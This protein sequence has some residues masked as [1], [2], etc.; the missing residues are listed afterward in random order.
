MI[1]ICWIILHYCL[2]PGKPAV[3]STHTNEVYLLLFLFLQASYLS[4]ILVILKIHHVDVVSR[5]INHHRDCPS[6]VNV[7]PMEVIILAFDAVEHAILVLVT[8][9]IIVAQQFLIKSLRYHMDHLLIAFYVVKAPLI[10]RC[11]GFGFRFFDRLLRGL[12]GLLAHLIVPPPCFKHV[13]HR[14]IV[15]VGVFDH[16]LEVFILQLFLHVWYSF[17]LF[18]FLLFSLMFVLLLYHL[19]YVMIQYLAHGALLF[20]YTI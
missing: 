16:Y 4:E 14:V 15:D 2:S 3:I 12:L 17:N 10:T 5:S 9:F 8:R 11:S 18:L 20:P 19:K 7:R 6:H 1:S 13:L